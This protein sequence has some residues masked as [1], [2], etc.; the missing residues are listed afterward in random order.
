MVGKGQEKLS[1]ATLS[2]SVVSQDWGEGGVAQRLREALAERLASTS[3]VG[4]S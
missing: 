3:V 2:G 1:Q 4:K